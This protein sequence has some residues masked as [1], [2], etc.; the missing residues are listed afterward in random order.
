MKWGLSSPEKNTSVSLPCCFE[1]QRN[2]SSEAE[3]A[4]WHFGCS[5]QSCRGGRAVLRPLASSRRCHREGCNCVALWGRIPQIPTT[6]S[7]PQLQMVARATAAASALAPE[8]AKEKAEVSPLPRLNKVHV[9][10]SWFGGFF[11][12]EWDIIFVTITWHFKPFCG[13]QFPSE[14]LLLVIIFHLVWGAVYTQ[15]KLSISWETAS[16]GLRF[17]LKK[18]R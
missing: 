5:P 14:M 1:C 12:N 17:E 18:D 2:V 9:E 7:Q 8:E 10:S 3:A 13:R 16:H 15:S 6:P 11:Y 4:L